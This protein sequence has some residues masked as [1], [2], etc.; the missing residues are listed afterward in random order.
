MAHKKAAG[1]AKNLRDSNP[2][3]RWLKLSWWQFARA[4]N[5]IIRQKWDKYVAWKNTYTGKDYTLHAKVDGVVVFTSKNFVRFDWRKYKKTI[6]HVVPEWEE[7]TPAIRSQNAPVS[8]KVTT[9]K[10][11][12]KKVSTVAKNKTQE[13]T[14]TIDKD[15]LTK[16]EWVWP[17]IA[18]LLHSAW[19][20]TFADLSSTKVWDLRDILS[21]AWSHFA[22][23]DPKTRKK[24]STL[25][26]NGKRD[27]LKKLQ[28]EL[29]G[30]KE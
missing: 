23:H 25:A 21:K 6:C 20:L 19:I 8:K 1:S 3:Y 14:V 11:E 4:W 29:D 9:K 16:I 12:K 22:M 10:V 27:E 5:I 13:K 15:D 2:K 18:Q 24:Q 30:W 26:K 7:F 17:K 28:D